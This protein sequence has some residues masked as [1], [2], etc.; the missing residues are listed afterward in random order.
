MEMSAYKII[1]TVMGYHWAKLNNTK[2]NVRR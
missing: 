2:N 1:I